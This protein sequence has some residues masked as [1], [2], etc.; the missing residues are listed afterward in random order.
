MLFRSDSPDLD[1]SPQ[2]VLV[3]KGIGLIGNP[4]MPE[5]GVIP[6]PRKLGNKGVKD[7]LRLSDGR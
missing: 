4:G 3:L 2:S 6:I 5:A 7:M 1:V